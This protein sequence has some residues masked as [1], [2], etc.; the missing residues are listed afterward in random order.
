ML[1]PPVAFW[2]DV[3]EMPSQYLKNISDMV[4]WFS[5]S[6]AVIKV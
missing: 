5:R 3:S 6:F 1:H 4:L 2:V